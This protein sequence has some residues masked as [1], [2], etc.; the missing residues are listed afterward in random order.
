MSKIKEYKNKFP[1]GLEEFAKALSDEIRLSIVS[2][3]Y[4]TKKPISED[5]T[6]SLF[7]MGDCSIEIAIRQLSDFGIIK[8]VNNVWNGETFLSDYELNKIYEK[9]LKECIDILSIR[10]V[11][12]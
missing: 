3:L 7:G 4:E 6:V 2:L 8:R 11:R 1:F 12:K 10:E 5:E 9:L